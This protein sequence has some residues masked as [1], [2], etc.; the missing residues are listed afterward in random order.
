MTANRSQ[1]IR[2]NLAAARAYRTGDH[3]QAHT[4]GN[5]SPSFNQAMWEACMRNVRYSMLLERIG[6]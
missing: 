2:A 6:Q 4:W 1:H 3:S 5:G